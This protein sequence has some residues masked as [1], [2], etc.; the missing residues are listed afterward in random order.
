MG[1]SQESAT[2][3]DFLTA[4][5]I[6]AQSM[7]TDSREKVIML[8]YYTQVWNKT[9]EKREP[10]NK[11][12]DYSSRRIILRLPRSTDLGELYSNC[13]VSSTSYANDLLT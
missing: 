7:K 10:S 12:I 8:Q 5:R 6:L 9:D 4:P 2:A 13:I 11:N 3:N 1:K